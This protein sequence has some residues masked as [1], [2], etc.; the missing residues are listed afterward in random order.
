MTASSAKPS[1]LVVNHH[2]LQ[3]P[4]PL[5]DDVICEWPLTRNKCNDEGQIAPGGKAV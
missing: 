5:A 3:T 1:S 2:P 4:Y